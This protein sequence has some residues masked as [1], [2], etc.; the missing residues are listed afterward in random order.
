MIDL[1]FGIEV[2]LVKIYNINGL[3]SIFC[4]GDGVV[5]FKKEKESGDRM[6]VYLSFNVKTVDMDGKHGGRGSI[7][8]FSKPQVG[9][10]L[11]F[12]P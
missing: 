2:V 9:Y 3:D 5:R 12:E 10:V 4:T 6:R 7:R 1:N 8:T 11:T